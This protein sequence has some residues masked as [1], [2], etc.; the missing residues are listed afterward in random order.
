MPGV[1]QLTQGLKRKGGSSFAG[2]EK[3]ETN[4]SPDRY[5]PFTTALLRC[6]LTGDRVHLKVAG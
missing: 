3:P 4:V 5:N 1:I 2:T 6:W